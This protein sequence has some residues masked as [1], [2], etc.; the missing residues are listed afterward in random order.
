MNDTVLTLFIFYQM[1]NWT[2]HLLFLTLIFL[3]CF[4]A[5]SVL[6]RAFCCELYS[7]ADYVI[8]DI[9][10]SDHRGNVIWFQLMSAD[11]PRGQSELCAVL[12]ILKTDQRSTL[13][14]SNTPHTLHPSTQTHSSL[15]LLLTNIHPPVPAG[16]LV[17][18]QYNGAKSPAHPAYTCVCVCMYVCMY[19]FMYV[20]IYI[21]IYI[22]R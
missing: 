16:A 20:Y 3:S 13:N 14:L 8:V 9:S 4:V 1:M 15:Y 21:Y 5:F 11:A 19:V 22:Y 12:S 10:A 7:P 17:P 2:A 6:H 18:S